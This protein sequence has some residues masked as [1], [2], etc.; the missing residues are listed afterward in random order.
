MTCNG[1]VLDDD[2]EVLVESIDV[3]VMISFKSKGLD[4]FVA[5]WSL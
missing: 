5:A 4:P 3:A 1:V 2:M